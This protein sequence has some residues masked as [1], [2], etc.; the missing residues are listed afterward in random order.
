MVDENQLDG[1][2]NIPDRELSEMR[3]T[4][5]STRM[6]NAYIMGSMFICLRCLAS[7]TMKTCASSRPYTPVVRKAVRAAIISRLRRLGMGHDYGASRSGPRMH[8]TVL[9]GTLQTAKHDFK[10]IAEPHRYAYGAASVDTNFLTMPRN[11]L[12]LWTSMFAS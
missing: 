8:I 12:R 7:I 9:T 6:E 3:K 5:P 4:P 11:A 10:L 1:V 2:E